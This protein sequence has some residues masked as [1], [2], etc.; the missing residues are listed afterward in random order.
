M[1]QGIDAL[2]ELRAFLS[3][4]GSDFRF[5]PNDLR[6]GTAAADNQGAESQERHG[7]QLESVIV[8]LGANHFD[9]IRTLILGVVDVNLTLIVLMPNGNHTSRRRQDCWLPDARYAGPG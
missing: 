5:P 8:V 9:A 1:R 2:L 3:G 7:H 6:M 4:Q